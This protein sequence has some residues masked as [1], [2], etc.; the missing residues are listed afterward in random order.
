MSIYE[1]MPL[2]GDPTPEQIAQIQQENFEKEMAEA[3]IMYDQ[4]MKAVRNG[5]V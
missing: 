5:R 1:F 4:T 3:R 2:A